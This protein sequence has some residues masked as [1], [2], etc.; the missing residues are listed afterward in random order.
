MKGDRRASRLALRA[1]RRTGTALCLCASVANL[2]FFLT[3]V[4]FVINRRWKSYSSTHAS[5]WR[6]LTR[7]DRGSG[8]WGKTMV[9]GETG[10]GAGRLRVSRCS[11]HEGR[12]PGLRPHMGAGPEWQ[13]ILMQHVFAAQHAHLVAWFV[14]ALY[15]DAGRSVGERPE[16]LNVEGK[17]H[18]QWWCK[19]VTTGSRRK[20]LPAAHDG[21]RKPRRACASDGSAH[22]AQCTVGRVGQ[23]GR[24]VPTHLT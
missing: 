24:Y 22:S 12:A 10:F 3:Y 9:R 16:P 18:V 4:T 2:A 8:S 11:L 20:C 14:F 17:G 13:A 21:T 15:H 1:D 19:R 6:S 7:S 5:A 23:A